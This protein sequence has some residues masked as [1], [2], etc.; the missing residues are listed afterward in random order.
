MPN[1]TEWRQ[2]T[3][4]LSVHIFF[5]IFEVY[6]VLFINLLSL[7]NK[8]QL[9]KH[10][11]SLDLF[12]DSPPS[13]TC[14][15]Q[16]S[17]KNN[18]PPHINKLWVDVV[19]SKYGKIIMH[20]LNIRKTRIPIFKTNRIRIESTISNNSRISNIRRALPFETLRGKPLLFH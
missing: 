9:F 6:Q 14:N 13:I 8:S 1:I 2:W 11:T 20:E 16:P 5:L 10:C 19:P 12:V 4:E 18:L 15:Q 7:T 17:R 3:G